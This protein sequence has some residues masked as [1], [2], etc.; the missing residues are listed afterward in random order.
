[1]IQILDVTVKPLG[2][3]H[4]GQIKFA[5][6]CIQCGPV[7]FGRIKIIHDDEWLL[8]SGDTDIECSCRLDEPPTSEND[9]ETYVM[10]FLLLGTAFP[11]RPQ[12]FL[13]LLLKPTDRQPVEYRHF[14]IFQCLPERHVLKKLGM[15]VVLALLGIEVENGYKQ[16]LEPDKD[17]RKQ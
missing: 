17:G 10:L 16:V 12:A 15:D 8:F 6:L 4:F 11:K 3:G 5:S 14:G 13:G 1:M 7:K 2:V 9:G